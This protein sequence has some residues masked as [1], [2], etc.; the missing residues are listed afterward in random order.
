MTTWVALRR[1][2]LR[3][4]C[5]SYWCREKSMIRHTGGLALGATSTRSSSRARAAARASGRFTTPS[6]SPAS[7]MSRTSRARIR[8]FVLGS[9]VAMSAPRLQMGDAGL[10]ATMADAGS[11]RHGAGTTIPGVASTDP[12]SGTGDRPGGSG[13]AGCSASHIRL[14]G[15]WCSRCEDTS[16]SSLW[17]PSGEHR[18]E[19]ED[20]ATG[21]APGDPGGAAERASAAGVP[22]DAASEAEMQEELRRV[23]AELAHTPVA[24]LIANHA[25][26]L[27]QLAVLHLTP[28][29]GQPV[30]LDEAGLAIDAMASLVEGLGDRLGEAAEPLRD[31][32][33]QLRMAFVQITERAEA[34]GSPEPEST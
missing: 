27:W 14:S 17:T 13:H 9:S 21:P 22:P 8:S 2:S 7:P 25:I 28:E 26:G 3:R 5:S 33:A 32:L 30:R 10:D 16:V 23:R 12:G 34:G 4:C 15:A 19:G 29:E 24:D 11:V 31:A 18:P 20:P 1:D 6:C